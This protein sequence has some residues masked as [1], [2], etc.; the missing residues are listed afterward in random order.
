MLDDTH[1][2]IRLKGLHVDGVRVGIYPHEKNGQQS[3]V[4]DVSLWV[5]VRPAA[6]SENI[7]DAI[8]YDGIA[9]LVRGISRKRYYPLLE[10]LCEKMAAALLERPGIERVAVEVAKPGALAPGG[11][12]VAVERSR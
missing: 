1:G 8:D 12:S 7:E 3:V 9:D 6:D 2:W 10:S 11:V 4:V 5:A